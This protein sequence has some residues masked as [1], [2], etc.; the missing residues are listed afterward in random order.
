M[1]RPRLTVEQQIAVVEELIE[2]FRWARRPGSDDKVNQTYRVLKQIAADLRGRM[3]D[4]IPITVRMLQQRIDCAVQS[5]HA[6][7]P[8][9]G[10]AEELIGRWATVRLA[11]ERLAQEEETA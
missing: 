8:M 4:S 6:P 1:M 2:G 11:L 10:V 7:G 3:A 9:Q 5:K